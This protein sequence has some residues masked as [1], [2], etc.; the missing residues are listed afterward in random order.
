[1]MAKRLVGKK[2]KNGGATALYVTVILIIAVLI[3]LFLYVDE[4]RRHEKTRTALHEQE[5]MNARLSALAEAAQTRQ[6]EMQDTITRLNKEVQSAAGR[7]QASQVAGT[8]NVFQRTLQRELDERNAEIRKH[9]ESLRKSEETV[10]GFER[11]QKEF[12][13]RIDAL[14]EQWRLEDERESR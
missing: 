14:K 12:K 1:M 7:E 3:F 10:Q 13:D 4:L 11:K 8:M 6:K 5:V 9:E 2:R